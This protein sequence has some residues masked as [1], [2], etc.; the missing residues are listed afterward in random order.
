MGE[1]ANV[2]RIINLK[3]LHKELLRHSFPLC[4]TEVPELLHCCANCNEQNFYIHLSHAKGCF[5]ET[6]SLKRKKSLFW[7]GSDVEL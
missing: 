1:V 6:I 2:I 3:I 7:G 5:P 4:S